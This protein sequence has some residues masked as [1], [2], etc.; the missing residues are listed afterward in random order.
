MENAL[1]ASVQRGVY[2]LNVDYQIVHL[3]WTTEVLAYI[4]HH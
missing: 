2:S 3:F 1:P 4:V